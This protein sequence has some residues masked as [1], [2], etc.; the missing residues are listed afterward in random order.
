V[1]ADEKSRYGTLFFEEAV[2][3][4]GPEGYGLK[5]GPSTLFY[6]SNLTVIFDA[7]NICPLSSSRCKIVFY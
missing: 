4:Y 6:T 3:G 7:E 2:W 1:R 5:Y